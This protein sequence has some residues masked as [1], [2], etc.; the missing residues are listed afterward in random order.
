[1]FRTAKFGDFWSDQIFAEGPREGFQREPGVVPN[2]GM[3]GTE[4]PSSED[5]SARYSFQ[6]KRSRLGSFPGDLLPYP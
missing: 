3:F 1:M 4:A 2:Y 6:S 5:C